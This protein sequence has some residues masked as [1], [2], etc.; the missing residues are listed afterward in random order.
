MIRP[1]A[2]AQA[3]STWLEQMEAMLP[4]VG[5]KTAA[6]WAAKI[7]QWRQALPPKP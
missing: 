5:K 3:P 7:N 4:H 6:A 1:D 2:V